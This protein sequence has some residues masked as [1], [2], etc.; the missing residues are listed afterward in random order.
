MTKKP[1]LIIAEIGVNHNG[2]IK[3][4]KKLI[5]KAKDCGADF[6]KFQIYET[7]NMVTKNAPKAK[8]QINKKNSKETHYEMLKKY[9]VN[10]NFLKKISDYSKKKKINF[11]ASVFDLNSL[12]ILKKINPKYIKIP[13][14]EITN[15]PLLEK[16]GKLNLKVIMS[17]GMSNMKE[18]DNALKVLIKS[19]TFK[20]NIIILHCTT[21]YPTKFDDVNLN[22]M[23]KIKKKLNIEIGYS[24]HTKGIEVA[25]AAISLGAKVIEKHFTL[26]KRLNGP[27]HL[28]SLN[29][30]EF[31]EMVKSIRNVE[32]AFGSSLKKPTKIETQNSLIVRKSI[33]AQK[34]I[35]KGEKFSLENICIKRPGVGKSPMMWY[36][37]IGK[38]SKKNYKADELI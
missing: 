31:K 16:I 6:V 36:K 35:K 23:L 17:S 37:L 29:P 10:S 3:L 32:N 30:L 18:L 2:D 15:L 38:K 22:A 1:L 9:E 24:D 4:A 8:Y 7:T 13:S 34:N 19:G 20:K 14:G 11:L 21:S 12:N 28:S 26:N 25:I 5:D 27:D 33:F